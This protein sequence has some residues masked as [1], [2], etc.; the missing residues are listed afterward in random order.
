VNNPEVDGG[1]RTYVSLAQPCSDYGGSTCGSVGKFV[2]CIGPGPA[3][4][5]DS[6]AGSTLTACI[7]GHQARLDCTHYG[8]NCLADRH[9]DTDFD[10]TKSAF[11]G[12]GTECGYDYADS[13]KGNILTYCDAGRIATLDCVKTGWNGC[14]SDKQGTRC[15]P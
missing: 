12:L 11:C 5:E 3:C 10:S 9:P 7:G 13:C 15:T 2:G 14:A 8:L 4:T 6:C 1:V